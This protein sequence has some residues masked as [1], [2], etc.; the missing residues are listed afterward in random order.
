MGKAYIRGA[1]I[2]ASG[3]MAQ[4]NKTGS[5]RLSEPVVDHSKCKGCKICYEFCP[6]ECIERLDVQKSA[7]PSTPRIKIDMD[8]C[9]GC[10]ICAYECPQGAITMVKC[11][12]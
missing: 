4:I 7:P 11:E 1:G 10:G 9:K 3:T 2:H 5:W 8:Y 6:D 12:A